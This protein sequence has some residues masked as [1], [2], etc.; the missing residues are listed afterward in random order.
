MY[1]ISHTPDY[2]TAGILSKSLF[3]TLGKTKRLICL[4]KICFRGSIFHNQWTLEMSTTPM[5]ITLWSRYVLM[6]VYP[7]NFN[8]QQIHCSD[9]SRDWSWWWHPHSVLVKSKQPQTRGDGSWVVLCIMHGHAD[10]Q[11]N[12]LE[13]KT[14]QAARHA[15]NTEQYKQLERSL[16]EWPLKILS[17]ITKIAVNIFG[18]PWPFLLE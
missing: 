14:K 2:Q 17:K 3:L 5:R 4:P 1:Y 9:S 6:Q 15:W 16:R 11:W 18:L 12:G 10:G 8:Q 7:L 13:E